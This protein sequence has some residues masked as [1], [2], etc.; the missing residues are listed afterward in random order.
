MAP[1]LLAAAV[2]FGPSVS[3]ADAWPS[4]PITLMIPYPPGGSADM[5]ARPVAAR[6]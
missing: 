3:A 2:L 6:L 5:L 4:K 1:A